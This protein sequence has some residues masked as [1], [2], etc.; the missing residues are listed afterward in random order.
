MLTAYTDLMGIQNWCINAYLWWLT[1]FALVVLQRKWW[2]LVL[3][4]MKINRDHSG[5]GTCI[6]YYVTPSLIGWAHIQNNPWN[7]LIKSPRYTG[8]DFMFLYRFVR[9][10]RQRLQI[11]VHAITFE[12][13][14]GFLS[15]LARL[16]ALTCRLSDYRLVSN[17]RRVL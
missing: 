4:S 17:I 6:T 5:Y 12:R 8:G 7:N 9:L 3:I 14:F 13:L 11:L 2:T 15:F 1:E 16:L 10:R